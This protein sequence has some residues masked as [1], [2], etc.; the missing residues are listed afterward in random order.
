M[1]RYDVISYLIISYQCYIRLDSM[2]RYDIILYVSASGWTC[3]G[4]HA[5]HVFCAAQAAKLRI[6]VGPNVKIL[7]GSNIRVLM[8]QKFGSWARGPGPMALGPWALGLGP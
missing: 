7:M 5:K 8:G 2:M 1:L 4:N 6:L 3:Q